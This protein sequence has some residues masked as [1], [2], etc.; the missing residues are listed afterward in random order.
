M[1]TLPWIDKLYTYGPY[2]VFSSESKEM[3][4][5]I[6]LD[7]EWTKSGTQ[8]SDVNAMYQANG[9]AVDNDQTESITLTAAESQ[10]P[11]KR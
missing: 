6:I 4:S 1:I 10:V 5:T 8:S 11:P 3:S 2:D 9:A 7:E